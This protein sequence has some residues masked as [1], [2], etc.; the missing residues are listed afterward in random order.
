MVLH[1]RLLLW[2][3][4]QVTITITGYVSMPTRGTL[5]ERTGILITHAG[6]EVASVIIQ[7]TKSNISALTDGQHCNRQTLRQLRT[8]DDNYQLEIDELSAAYDAIYLSEYQLKSARLCETFNITDGRCHQL[9]HRKRR[10]FT[11]V[12]ALATAATALDLSL[13][14]EQTIKQIQAMM[15][16]QE[17]S[18]DQIKATL[19]ARIKHE[20][21]FNQKLA[22][23]TNQLFAYTRV[24][25]KQFEGLSVQ[26]NCEV[27]AYAYA[28]A[29]ESIDQLKSLLQF[30]L[31]G[32]LSGRVTP[33]LLS[34]DEVKHLAT[35]QMAKTSKFFAEFPHILYQTATATLVEADFEKLQFQF[36]LL[37]PNM[38]TAQLSA[39]FA[40][41][42][43][44]F[45]ARVTYDNSTTCLAFNTPPYATFQKG[46]WYVLKTPNKCPSFAR[47][48]ICQET[49]YELLDFNDCLS[50]GSGKSSTCPLITCNTDAFISTP[51][52]LL[53]R[54][55]HSKIQIAS[56]KSLSQGTSH[57]HSQTTSS[58]EERL[59]PAHQVTFVKWDINTTSVSFGDIV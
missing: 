43:T 15:A 52:G 12:A 45:M 38:D 30:F 14:N 57:P 59:M 2:M 18:I 13:Q 11:G 25:Q 35:G 27:S 55:N 51:A 28:L 3:A 48:M 20:N 39:F 21:K 37:F 6:Y 10:F 29:R 26:L 16:K 47:A 36:I 54:T 50:P 34:V 41:R 49:Q 44:G 22:E 24:L 31:N 33:S 42:Q 7:L 58:V 40:I 56:Q 23:A 17:E 1:Y 19:A 5:L 32:K 9:P 8:A 53:L 46:R 4:I